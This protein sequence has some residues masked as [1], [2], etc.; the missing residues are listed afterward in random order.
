MNLA[1]LEYLVVLVDVGSYSQAAK[2]LYMSP[3]AIAKSITNMERELDVKI[4]E[5]SGRGIRVTPFAID[6][7]HLAETALQSVSEIR[8]LAK[9]CA[10]LCEP[11][12]DPSDEKHTSLKTA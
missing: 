8:S 6:A 3:Q 7:A 12:Y 5:R 2:E 9:D 10:P 1:Q 11:P 4:V